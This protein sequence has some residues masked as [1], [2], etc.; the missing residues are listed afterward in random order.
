MI[1]LS[2]GC[3]SKARYPVPTIIESHKT[4]MTKFAFDGLVYYSICSLRWLLKMWQLFKTGFADI[5]E[6]SFNT[7]NVTNNSTLTSTS[8]P[9]RLEEYWWWWWC[10]YQQQQQQYYC[11]ILLA[12][13]SIGEIVVVHWYY[14]YQELC[15]ISLQSIQGCQRKRKREP[16][17]RHSFS[18]WTK[19]LLV[20]KNQQE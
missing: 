10:Y 6:C 1:I 3:I 12:A 7:F 16:F 8:M 15:L 14:S 2:V 13:F 11:Q 9:W 4:R 5:L 20:K 18:S 19:L 17:V